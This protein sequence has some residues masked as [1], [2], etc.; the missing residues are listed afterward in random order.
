[1]A[2]TAITTQPVDALG[3]ADVTFE[4]ANVDGNSAD[5]E[6]LLIVHNGSGGSVTVTVQTPADVEG[7][8]VAENALAVGA[9]DY[10]MV[11]LATGVYGRPVGSADAGKVYVDYSAVTSV[12]VAVVALS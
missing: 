3:D 8:A 1:M 4:A 7:L 10:A 12:E 9:G 6:T 11:R 5:V 2:R